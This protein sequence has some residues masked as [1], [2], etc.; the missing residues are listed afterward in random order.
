MKYLAISVLALT[1]LA[2]SASAQAPLGPG[3]WRVEATTSALTDEKDVVASL[4]SDSLLVNTIDLP[5]AAA[6]I[7]RCK[8]GALAVYVAWPQV[9]KQNYDATILS[10]PETNAYFRL[11]DGKVALDFW[12]IS[13]DQTGAGRF[14]TKKAAKLLGLLAGAHKLVV[15]LSSPT[16]ETQDAIFHLD[17]LD[18]IAP[19][20]LQACGVK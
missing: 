10:P 6:L 4:N 8:E 18:Q 1:V 11:D 15:R 7:V 9:I 5:E 20:V 16:D 14:S 17:G 12:E 13:E 2:S 3:A 19:Q